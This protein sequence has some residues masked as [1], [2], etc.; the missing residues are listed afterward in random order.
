MKNIILIGNPNTGKTTLFNL[1]TKSFEHTGNWHGVTIDYKQKQFEYAGKDFC[2]VD[3]PGIYSLTPNSFEEQVSVDYIHQ[4]DGL[5]LCL[6]DSENLYRNLYLATEI[7]ALGREMVICI[8]KTSKHFD[9]SVA[10]KIENKFGVKCIVCDLKQKNSKQ[11]IMELFCENKNTKKQ[12]NSKYKQKILDF[13]NKLNSLNINLNNDFYAS[14]IIYQDE[15]YLAKCHINKDNIQHLCDDKLMEKQI[16][17]KYQFIEEIFENQ[18]KSKEIIGKSFLDKIVLNKFLAI[19]I[20]IAIMMLI[21]YLTFFSVGAYLS[22][23]LNFLIQDVIG[24]K[25]VEF[26]KSFCSVVWV[27]DLIEVG[28]LGGV[29]TILSFLPQVVMLFLF[30]SILEESGYISRLA[31]MADDLLSKVGLCGKSVYTLLM[32]FGCSTTA[33]LTA[34]NMSD[35]NSKI[36]TAI[37][38]PYMSCSA[39]L[40]VYAVI[41]G[42]FFGANNVF[43]VTF[44]YILGV[45]VALLLSYILDKTF[46]KSNKQSFILEFPSYRLCGL[47]KIAKVVLENSKLFLVRIG[48][49][50]ISLNVIIWVLESFSFGFSYV[51]ISGQKSILQVLGTIIAPIF[52]P[53]G[54]NNWGATSAL[55]A[56]IIAKEVVVSAIAMFNGI[57]LK[58]GDNQALSNSLLS[59]ESVVFFSPAGAFSYM[60]FCLLYCPCIATISV[61]VKE[62]GKKWTVISVVLQFVLAYTVGLIFNLLATLSGIYG[63]MWVLAVVCCLFVILISFISF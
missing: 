38:A 44:L 46:L 57:D 48:S 39:K 42:A 59:N 1:L 11:K 6:C 4:N 13:K 16:Q 45:V 56:G 7:F 55:V 3:L 15:Y 26:V 24:T 2:L 28:I 35:K 36:K 12:F 52:A 63:I 41:G 47:K 21:F 61:L 27:I 22:D 58:G 25:V 50:L 40:P 5:I 60:I 29:G 9:E 34:R 30:L 32:G 18:K 54:F 62:I 53:L 10:K 20:F 23:L 33:C 8:N 17:E 19:P 37:L 31:F 51:P 43:V 49:L 14:K